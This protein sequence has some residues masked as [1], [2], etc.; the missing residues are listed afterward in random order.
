MRKLSLT[1]IATVALLGT[2]LIGPRP[3]APTT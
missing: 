1:F 2:A 3:P